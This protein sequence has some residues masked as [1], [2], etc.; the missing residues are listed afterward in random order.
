MFKLPPYI[1]KKVICVSICCILVSVSMISKA[2][3]NEIQQELQNESNLFHTDLDRPDEN[4]EVDEEELSSIKETQLALLNE[5][6]FALFD[7]FTDPNEIYSDLS[8]QYDPQYFYYTDLN[9]LSFNNKNCRRFLNTDGKY[10]DFGRIIND[11]FK[12]NGEQSVLLSN[13]I[14]GMT[15]RPKICPNWKSLTIETKVKFWVWTFASIAFSE[16]SC[17]PHPQPV[18]GPTDMTA[19]LLQLEAGTRVVKGRKLGLA[20]R[21]SRGPN[22]RV[23]TKDIL[24]PYSNIRCGLDMMKQQLTSYDSLDSILYDYPIYPGKGMPA[25]SYWLKLRM[26]YGGMIGKNMRKFKPCFQ[27]DIKSSI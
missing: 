14:F 19:G 21:L 23:S 9:G 25:K 6:S 20:L 2:K 16:S 12:E 27:E 1:T 13:G 24:K 26:E 18:Y 15:E 17:N 8:N 11:Y 7:P 10:G 3:K 5:R 4:F 22:C